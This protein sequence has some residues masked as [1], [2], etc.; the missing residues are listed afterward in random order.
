MTN[1]SSTVA[2]TPKLKNPSHKRGAALSA[3]KRANAA[4]ANATVAGSS[5][6]QPH[7]HDPHHDSTTPE[8]VIPSAYKIVVDRVKVAAY[9]QRWRSKEKYEVRLRPEQLK[10]TPFLVQ[11]NYGMDIMP[12]LSAVGGV[13][14]SGGS[15]GDAAGANVGVGGEASGS[16]TIREMINDGDVTLLQEEML[17]QQEEDGDQAEAEEEEEEDE[18]EDEDEDETFDLVRGLLPLGS[19]DDDDDFG[20]EEEEDEEGDEEAT[21]RTRRK[22]QRRSSRRPVRSCSSRRGSS[23]VALRRTTRG[24]G[25]ILDDTEEEENEEDEEAEGRGARRV[26][27]LRR[28]RTIVNDVKSSPRYEEDGDQDVQGGD[29]RDDDDEEE[30]VEVERFQDGLGDSIVPTK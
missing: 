6:R 15:G 4:F 3:R 30:D 10:W 28:S 18:D 19:D 14:N 2:A 13:L 7:A 17:E 21:G 1:A 22:R 20:S 9:V 26:G 8:L 16:G 23:P 12:V 11:R 27:S 29:D 5:S 24:S 25:M